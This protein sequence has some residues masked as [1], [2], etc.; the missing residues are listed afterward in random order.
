MADASCGVVER[1][2][3]VLAAAVVAQLDVAR[4]EL[5]VELPEVRVVEVER[6]HELVDLHEVQAALLLP[7]VDER[8]ERALQSVAGRHRHTVTVLTGKRTR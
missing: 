1:A 2:L 8:G 6:L 4:V 5:L 7:P 3:L